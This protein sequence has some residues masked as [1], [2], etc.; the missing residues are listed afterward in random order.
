MT[1]VAAGL[2]D[3]HLADRA[4]DVEFIEQRLDRAARIGAEL[5]EARWPNRTWPER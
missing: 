1:R 5:M 3:R 4:H 2:I